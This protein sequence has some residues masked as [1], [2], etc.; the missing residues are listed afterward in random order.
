M[1]TPTLAADTK[2]LHVA[3]LNR[4]YTISDI[5]FTEDEF[6]PYWTGKLNRHG[7]PDGVTGSYYDLDESGQRRR[8]KEDQIAA[9]LF[10]PDVIDP[11]YRTTLIYDGS[12]G[13]CRRTAR[14]VRE[15]DK[16]RLLRIS[17][18]QTHIKQERLSDG[19]IR[20]H[21]NFLDAIS[22]GFWIFNQLNECG[23]E[24]VGAAA[25]ICEL[26]FGAGNWLARFMRVWPIVQILWRVHF[27]VMDHRGLLVKFWNSDVVIDESEKAEG[28]TKYNLESDTW[29]AFKDA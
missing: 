18:F 20:L 11:A 23:L 16:K 8:S 17:P 1:P 29:K 12:C 9:L 21:G 14:W 25:E 13:F 27:W 19:R 5:T 26:I 24:G 6:G 7:K 3:K 15:L 2:A 10:N 22:A 28:I 4:D